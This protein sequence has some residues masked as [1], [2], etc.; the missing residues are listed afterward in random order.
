MVI[1]T[2]IGHQ[3]IAIHHKDLCAR[4]GQ[5]QVVETKEHQ[6]Y[7]Q[8]SKITM[9]NNPQTKDIKHVFIDQRR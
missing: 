1:E 5:I 2:P 9:K 3:D 8:P 6:R 4:K 7:E